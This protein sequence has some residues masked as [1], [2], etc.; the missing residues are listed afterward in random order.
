MPDDAPAPPPSSP[1][2]RSP[3]QIDFGC[4]VGL[5]LILIV[6]PV[7][8]YVAAPV[9]VLGI[10]AAVL[11]WGLMKI[12]PQRLRTPIGTGRVWLLWFL[13]LVLIEIGIAAWIHFQNQ[14]G[15][16]MLQRM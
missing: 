6:L 4:M 8:L 15:G 10:V 16:E 3:D 9:A 11:A 14:S 1:A 5:A 2:P 13:L 7:S 12:T